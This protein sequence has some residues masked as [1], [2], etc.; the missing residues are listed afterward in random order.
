MTRE[1]MITATAKRIESRCP[2]L[3]DDEDIFK[4]YPTDYE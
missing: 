3:F 2:P 4:K 1:E